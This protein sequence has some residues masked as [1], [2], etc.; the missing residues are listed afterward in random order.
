MPQLGTPGSSQVLTADGVVGTSGAPTYVF[1]VTLRGGSALTRAD[2]H[3]G[4]AASD[5]RASG[6]API[7]DTATIDCGPNG[8]VFEDGCYL[9]IT[10]TAGSVTVVYSQ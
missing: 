9:D 8:I 4:T 2:L 6:T 7:T 10:T 3:N 5:L 1:A